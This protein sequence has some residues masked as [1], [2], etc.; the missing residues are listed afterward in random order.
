MISVCINTKN[1]HLK[2]ADCV[3]GIL[4]NEL[5][6][7]EIIIIDQ[8]SDKNS[9]R[10]NKALAKNCNLRYFQNKERGVGMAKNA[11]IK[12]ARG[13][14]LIFTDDDCIVDNHWLKNIYQSFQ[15][16]KDI[17]GVFGRVLPFEPQ[18]NKGKICPCTFLKKKKEIITQPCFHW[19]DIGFG[20]NMAFRRNI[21]DKVGGFRKWLGP[22][23]I[24]SNAE[25]AEFVLRLLFKGYKILYNPRILIYHNRWLNKE[26]FRKQGLSY[27][28]GEMACYGYF[29]FQGLNLGEKVILNNFKDSYWKLREMIKSI[30]FLKKESPQ[31][32]FYFFEEFYYRLRGLMIGLY[33]SKRERL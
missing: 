32:I 26:Q 25:D 6:N 29:A 9:I 31:I 28:C 30:L 13:N 1:R 24:G 21:F 3:N 27:I 16:N 20:N 33:F 8:S 12:H 23:S 22:G 15:D 5:K 17:I 18:L 19:K 10:R 4:K 7:L 14:I 2:L 11:A